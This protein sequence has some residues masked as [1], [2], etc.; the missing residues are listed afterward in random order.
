MSVSLIIL[1]AFALN[2]VWAVHNWRSEFR[3]I[4]AVYNKPI[5]INFDLS[6]I[7]F[8]PLGFMSDLLTTN[9][10]LVIAPLLLILDL[11]IT[12]GATKVFGFNGFQGSA[13]A[14]LMSN[15]LSIFFFTPKGEAKKILK[16]YEKELKNGKY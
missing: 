10:L 11:T 1:I 16:Q 2:I 13:M 3:L 5:D 6:E 12:G 9:K 14:I 4:K 8:N 7:I 15:V